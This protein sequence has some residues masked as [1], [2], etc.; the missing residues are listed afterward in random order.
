MASTYD[1]L[2]LIPH[3]GKYFTTC[4]ARK[5]GIAW[6]GTFTGRSN[7]EAC[8]VQ[9]LAGLEDH[10]CKE[11]LQCLESMPVEE[12]ERYLTETLQR[13]GQE[14]ERGLRM[15]VGFAPQSKKDFYFVTSELVSVD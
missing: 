14:P 2:D 12:R 10:L 6:V 7:I 13:Y 3:L 8:E 1:P 5:Y 9:C 15:M 11:V 4:S